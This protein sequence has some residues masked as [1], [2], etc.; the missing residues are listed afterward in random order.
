MPSPVAATEK[1]AVAHSFTV[2]LDGWRV[3]AGPMRTVS[4]AAELVTRLPYRSVTTQ[5]NFLPFRP[6]VAL[7][8]SVAVLQPVAEVLFHVEAPR[9]WYCHW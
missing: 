1:V 6:A 4:V 9:A 7:T 5:R 8:L 3:M 2:A